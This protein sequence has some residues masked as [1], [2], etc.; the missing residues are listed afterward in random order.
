MTVNANDNF[1]GYVVTCTVNANAKC[2]KLL[3]SSRDE[4]YNIPSI[5]LSGI[6]VHA[7]LVRRLDLGINTVRNIRVS[8]YINCHVT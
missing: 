4:L 6:K 1:H 7:N 8:I 5:G 2:K 3:K